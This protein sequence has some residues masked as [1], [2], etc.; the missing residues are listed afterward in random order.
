M[1]KKPRFSIA[2]PPKFTQIRTFGLRT[3]HLAT[4]DPLDKSF[5]MF[6][7]AVILQKIL[8]EQLSEHKCSV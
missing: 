6:L 3:N 2:N 5:K 4:L 8:S 1:V 7:H